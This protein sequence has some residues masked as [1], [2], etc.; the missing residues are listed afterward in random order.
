MRYWPK[1]C[2]KMI[3]SAE[4]ESFMKNLTYRCMHLCAEYAIGSLHFF[5]MLDWKKIQNRHQ[6]GR[7]TRTS[8]QFL[9]KEKLSW[10]FLIFPRKCLLSI[11]ITRSLML[12][13]VVYYNGTRHFGQ[14]DLSSKWENDCFNFTNNLTNNNTSYL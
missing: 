2:M 11:L 5:L 3:R 14:F 4:N 1:Y 8:L 13:C 10:N 12:C 6:P 9:E 7:G